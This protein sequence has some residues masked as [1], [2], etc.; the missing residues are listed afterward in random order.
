MKN[1][2]SFSRRNFIS[3]ASVLALGGT[4]MSFKKAP[5]LLPIPKT[6]KRKLC[7]EFTKEE[8]KLIE[9]SRM[10]KSIIEIEGGSCTE[11][12]LLVSLRF[13]GKPDEL[14]CFAAS[15]GGGIQH[16]DLCG[17]LTGGFMSIGLAAEVL[18]K[19]KDERSAFVKDATREYWEWWEEHAPCHCYELKPKYTWDSENY[20]RMLQRVALKLEDMLKPEV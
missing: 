13:F 3:A 4:M 16:Y 6:D 20:N 9:N 19:D 2:S 12:V 14:V 17:M 7:D 10:A 8:K 15:F 11:K 18:Y 1:H 5:N